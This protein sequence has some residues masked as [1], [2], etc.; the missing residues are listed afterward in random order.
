MDSIWQKNTELPVF[1]TAVEDFKTDVAIIG[2]GIAGLLC[3]H[4]L[5]EQGVNYAIL[6]QGKISQQT[7]AHTTGKITSQHGLIYSKLIKEFGQ[8]TAEAY[9]ELNEKALRQF[10]Q[11]S[12]NIDCDFQ[13]R[14]N[15]V[16]SLNDKQAVL[17]EMEALRK[18]GGAGTYTEKTELPFDVAGAV[19]TAGQAQFHPLKF[20]KAIAEELHIFEDTFAER[21]EKSGG[22]YV[23]H[24]LNRSHRRVKIRAERV[25]ITAHFP[26]IDRK[27][28]YFLKMYQSRSFVLTLEN[29]GLLPLKGMYIGDRQAKGDN[30]NLSFRDWNDCLL[31]GGAGGR[32]GTD[33]K[34]M[35][36]LR[37]EARILFPKCRET[38]SWSAQDCMTLDGVPYAGAYSRRDSGLFVASG[39]NK[40]GM[41]GAMISAMIL[42]GK[43]D[44]HLADCFRPQRSMMRSQLF[45]NTFETAKNFLKPTAPR[46]THLGCAL[47]WNV[48]EQS[49]DCSCHGSGFDKDGKVKHNPAQKPLK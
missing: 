35:D 5:K 9:R 12:Q 46:C 21:I 11:I 30:L 3:G 41:T 25:I 39:F 10:R 40:W 44:A 20:I 34:G 1:P 29:T 24:A 6:E 2:G 32:T 42:T 14:T 8:D 33:Y 13:I 15:Y 26:F 18:I 27:G 23:I 37:K 16:Y 38:A 31:F 4:F 17:E 49:Y 48:S 28:A 43:A 47:K 36:D 45:I 19:K 7:T 22:G